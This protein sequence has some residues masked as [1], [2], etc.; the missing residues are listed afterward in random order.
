MNYQHLKYFQIVAR[1]ENFLRASEKL[2][3]TQSALSR[4][5]AN[6]EDELGVELFERTGRT[7]R[8]TAYGKCFLQYVDQ[9]MRSIDLG[10]DEVHHMLGS[11]QGIIH[12]GCIYGYTYQY[13][14]NLI[15][16]YN[17]CYPDVRFLIKPDSTNAVIMQIH[18][19][20]CDIGIHSE[21][22]FINKFPD[23]DTFE[24]LREEIVV[25]VPKGH[26]LSRKKSCRLSEI[27]TH[28]LVSFDLSS[29]MFY[30]TKDMF[31]QAGLIFS[32]YITA[33]DDQSIANLVRSGM[34]L[35]C[36]LRNIAEYNSEACAI[37]S[38]EDDINKHL[39]ILL[40][41]KRKPHYSAAVASF[42][43]FAIQRKNASDI[44]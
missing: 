22:Q 42:L 33:T 36:V 18:L 6:L 2:F 34:G 7:V 35:A 40:T 29:G 23:L 24:L 17:Q 1:E 10:V 44:K 21:T 28:R 26:E 14:P 12:L 27:V 20:E 38:I 39:S 9:G 15:S 4:A 43:N 25:I 41:L 32:P 11:M 13:L 37:L 30:R 16:E 8:L 5:I 3:I 19:G 31:E